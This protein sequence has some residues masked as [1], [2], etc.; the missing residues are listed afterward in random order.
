MNLFL[1]PIH[2]ALKRFDLF[3]AFLIDQKDDGVL[4]SIVLDKRKKTSF[5]LVLNAQDMKEL[6]RV[7]A[8]Q[9]VPFGFHGNFFG[10]KDVES[11]FY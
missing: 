2:K 6:A 3:H 8:P 9:V 7:E 5:L 4:L 10:E 1:S 11:S